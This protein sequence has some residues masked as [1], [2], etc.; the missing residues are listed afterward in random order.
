MNPHEKAVDV[1]ERL[2]ASP[3]S[4]TIRSAS[5]LAQSTQIPGSTVH[6][7]AAFLESEGMLGKGPDGAFRH[8]SAASR[9][10]LS[11]MGFGDHALRVEP[12]LLWLRQSSR[13]TSFLAVIQGRT[14]LMGPHSNGRNSQNFSIRS[15]YDLDHCPD[16]SYGSDNRFYLGE[17]TEN[18]RQRL[19]SLACVARSK[20][21]VC[22]VGIFLPSAP[23]NCA[24]TENLLRSAQERFLQPAN[25]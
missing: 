12:I 3:L 9:I 17:R 13:Q 2:M 11:A 18:D 10:G 21:G 20:T 16:I 8:G 6:R 15:S 22:V 1:F 5:Q 24:T 23:E 25:Q 19:V 4:G 14:L 7:H